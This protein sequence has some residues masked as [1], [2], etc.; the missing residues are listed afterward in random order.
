VADANDSAAFQKL[1]ENFCKLHSICVD[2]NL[3][4]RHTEPA[5]AS[6]GGLPKRPR[7]QKKNTAAKSV[8]KTHLRPRRTSLRVIEK[9]SLEDCRNACPPPA[10]KP[11]RSVR[12]DASPAKQ[13]ARSKS[14]NPPL[15]SDNK[16]S[17][18]GQ[19]GKPSGV[20][21]KFVLVAS[22]LVMLE[23]RSDMRT[24]CLGDSLR[25]RG[26][27]NTLLIKVCFGH[28]RRYVFKLKKFH[29]PLYAQII[30]HIGRIN[31]TRKASSNTSIQR[32]HSFY[33]PQP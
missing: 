9:R 18:L 2:G 24:L 14:P 12:R 20:C 16:R 11:T 26:R 32:R 15:C 28:F 13:R 4:H 19:S 30:W 5:P 33:R 22:Y 27:C 1:E 17:D 8:K 6:G 10:S 29:S 25:R 3:Q 21:L 7:R 31:C 23:L